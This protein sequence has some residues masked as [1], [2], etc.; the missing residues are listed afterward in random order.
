MK[1]I[2]PTLGW[3]MAGLAVLVSFGIDFSNSAQGGAIDLR[4]RVVGARVLAHGIDPY[5]YQWREGEP[6]E[7]CDPLRDPNIP[8]SRATAAPPVI[9]LHLVFAPLPYRAA[10][11]LWLVAQ[12][13]LLLGTG[14][15]CFRAC[16]TPAQRG[17]V[18]VAV[19]GFTYTAGWRLHAERGQVYVLLSFLFAC[20]L[21]ATL[22][23][24]RGNSFL[25]GF[26]GGFLGTLRAPFL[27]LLP[28]LALHRR[29][30]LAGAA[31]GL[32]LGSGLPVLFHPG[33]W[34]DYSSAMNT[35]SD[36]YRLG[37]PPHGAPIRP[38]V[39]EGIAAETYAHPVE[40]PSNDFSAY[41][42][43]RRRGSG[44]LPALPL[45][46]AVALP[47]LFW[48]WWTRGRPAECLLTGVASWFFLTDLFLPAA[49]YSYNDV[50]I[51]NPILLG[52][53]T[54]RKFPWAAWPCVLAFP[55][56]W[57]VYA[58]TIERP[59]LVNL[60]VALFTISAILFLVPLPARTIDERD[61]AP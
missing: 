44:T 31:V 29:G 46:V 11:Y 58:F 18:V 47:L 49:R 1:G 59:S 36:L 10:Q 27:L 21:T 55:V 4:N 30:Q 19:V 54:A 51:L 50:L 12:W 60:P 37:Y 9:M 35:R 28:F 13:L 15:L 5:H 48:L 16:A 57:I 3:V 53:V 8:V 41:S 2:V 43:L 20:W 39:I 45:L 7:Y 14:W 40:I 25:A 38:A 33:I 32:L 26:I 6:P 52:I 56:G 24:K 17:L 61:G 42:L 23:P 34:S 22:D